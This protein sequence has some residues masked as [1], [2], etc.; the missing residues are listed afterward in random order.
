VAARGRIVVLVG[1]ECW[2][3]LQEHAS[4]AL[5][6]AM[7]FGRTRPPA[8]TPRYALELTPEEAAE[9][10]RW[11]RSMRD[12]L[13]PADDRY[14]VCGLCLERLVEALERPAPRDE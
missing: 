12:A 10:L 11:L 3:F 7:T 9:L 14:R 13:L 8:A 2:V 6:P 4:Q 5:P 1:E